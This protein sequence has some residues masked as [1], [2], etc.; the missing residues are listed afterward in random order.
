M[1]SAFQIEIPRRGPYC[2]QGKELFLPG[3]DYYSI[4]L[5]EGEIRRQ[6]FCS[7]CWESSARDQFLP[8]VHTSWKS[9]VAAG[10]KEEPLDAQSR[11]DKILFILNETLKKETL[12]PDEEVECFVL[13]LYLARR[14]RL[15]LRKELQKEGGKFNLYEV[16]DTEEMLYVRR[17]E[18]SQIATEKVQAELANKIKA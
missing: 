1:K 10:K 5:E 8:K 16:A 3:M 2:S 9:K 14:R 15:L 18:L 12:S 6:D 7:A 17:V 4:L 13:A 11:D